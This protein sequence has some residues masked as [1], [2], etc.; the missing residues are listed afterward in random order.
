MKPMVQGAA[1]TCTSSSQATCVTARLSRFAYT[2]LRRP[3]QALPM[4]STV[5]C[6]VSTCS[7]ATRARV[8]ISQS[9][10]CRALLP[11]PVYA[12][13]AFTHAL[14]LMQQQTCTPLMSSLEHHSAAML[15][16]W[17]KR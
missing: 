6:S 12:E 15:V 2:L 7:P 1:C 13:S 4:R 14:V 9:G 8:C 16:T 10:A 17:C 3:L 5:R 11:D